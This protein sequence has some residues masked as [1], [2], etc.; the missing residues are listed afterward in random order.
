MPIRADDS[1]KG[2]GFC[3]KVIRWGAQRHLSAL[4]PPLARLA[5]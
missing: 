3:Q 4:F 1:C 2:D 5:L